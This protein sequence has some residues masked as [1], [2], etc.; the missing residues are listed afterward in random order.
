MEIQDGQSFFVVVTATNL[1]NYTYS[2]RSDGVTIKLEPPLP[3]IV[4]DGDLVGVD[5]A[6]QTS[7]HKL[8]ANWD[9]FGGTWEESG[10]PHGVCS[11]S[12]SLGCILR[13]NCFE[14]ASYAT[15][16]PTSWLSKLCC[17][18]CIGFLDGLEARPT[19]NLNMP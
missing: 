2:L 10:T 18:S 4:R 14:H 5:L 1:L 11:S 8:S 15:V 3:G 7:L 13:N 17:H 16:K 9:G 12:S 19:L 6:Y